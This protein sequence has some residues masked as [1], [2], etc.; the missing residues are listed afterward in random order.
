M[1][2]YEQYLKK[3]DLLIEALPYIQKFHGKTVVIKYGGHA[4]LDED[5]KRK[6]MEDIVLLHSVGIHPV[7]I[8]GGGP[9]INAML[10]KVGKESQF[11][12]GLRVTDQETMDIALMVLVGKLSTEIVTGINALGGK[13]IGVSGTDANLLEAVKKP[14]HF[15]NEAGDSEEI[16]LGFVGEVDTVDP[17]IIQSLIDH[18]YI[19]V[20][21]PIASGHQGETFNIN[22]DTAAGEI[23]KALKAD[24]FLLLTDVPGVLRDVKDK[25]SVIHYIQEEEIPG[26]MAEGLIQGGMIPKVECCQNALKSGVGTAHILDGHIPHAIILELFTDAGIGTMFYKGEL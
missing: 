7:I 11:I 21:S 2:S 15:T 5:L 17:G 19:P 22:A 23:A 16:D 20:V 25:A 12:R 24:K 10:K 26:L 4:M 13:A 9:G 3:A 14:M 6:V 18:G 8:H 1:T